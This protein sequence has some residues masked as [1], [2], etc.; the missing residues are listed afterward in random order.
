MLVTDLMAFLRGLEP[1][2]RVAVLGTSFVLGTLTAYLMAFILSHIRA[3]RKAAP[4]TWQFEE[5]RKQLLRIGS[6]TY[7]LFQAVIDRWAE[8]ADIRHLAER[9][10]IERFLVGAGRDI[11]WYGAEWVAARC[12]DGLLC[13]LCAGVAASYLFSH[14][15]SLMMGVCSGFAF[16]VLALILLRRECL[17]RRLAIEA[18]LPFSVEV[19]ALLVRAGANFREALD[20]TV[21]ACAGHPLGG[22]LKQVTQAAERGIPMKRTL[23]QMRDRVDSMLVDELV[24]TLVEAEEL[25]TPLSETL[26]NMAIRMRQRRWQSIEE[27]IGQT[28]TM[29]DIP[30]LMVM[31]SC[32]MIVAAPFLLLAMENPLF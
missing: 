18:R 2:E 10:R 24:T 19:M 23:L 13:G 11:P 26:S 32:L 20:G 1:L 14:V 31:V 30:A 9:L 25:G 28:E 3:A 4:H 22:E 16:V 5:E 7:R 27:T 12:V 8:R 21:E 17:R 6:A 15:T 29:L